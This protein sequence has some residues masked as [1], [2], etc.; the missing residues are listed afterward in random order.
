MP[1]RAASKVVGDFKGT[2]ICD[3]YSAYEALRKESGMFRIA[4]CWVHARRKFIE[5]EPSAPK[6]CSEVLDLIG[7]L[8]EVERDIRDGPLEERLFARQQRSKPIVA[9]I[10]R[11]AL[12]VSALPQSPLGKAIGYLGSLWPGL[13]VFLDDPHVAPDNNAVER[14]LR[15]VV[16]GRKNHYGSKSRRGTEVAALFYSLIESPRLCDL[17][18][19]RYLKSAVRA[20]LDR[21]TIPPPHEIKITTDS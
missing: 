1:G 18:P 19:A 10:H 7:A 8:Y 11:W 4:H 14:A 6:E 13:Q 15:S 21:D 9:Q 17:D 5:A 16:L 3:G 2:L 12:G 20:A